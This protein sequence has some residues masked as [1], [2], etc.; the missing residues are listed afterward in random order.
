M[1]FDLHYFRQR[2]ANDTFEGLLMTVQCCVCK[3]IRK[4]AR[5]VK[6]QKVALVKHDISHGYCPKCAG[7]AF[8]KARRR[9]RSGALASKS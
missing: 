2:V 5:W 7:E 9:P 6:P 3:K 8:Q 4:G 1:A